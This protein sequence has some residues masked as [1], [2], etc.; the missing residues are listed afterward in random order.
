MEIILI[1]AAKQ[2]ENPNKIANGVRS[3]DKSD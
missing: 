2:A 1:T 3:W